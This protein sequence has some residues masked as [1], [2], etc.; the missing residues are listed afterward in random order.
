MPALELTQL[1]FESSA[2]KRLL[3]FMMEENVYLKN[4]ISEVVQ[5]S[6]GKKKLNEVEIFQNKFIMQ[7]E[8]IGLLRNDVAEFDRLLR[9][10]VIED[11]KIIADIGRK[12]RQLDEHI[13]D[14]EK[15][16]AKLKAEY[17]RFLHDNN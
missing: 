11:E 10:E 15:Q 1:Q 12:L 3:G 8:F 2:L 7:D 17:S 5:K 16:F 6:F 4:M 13:K 14:A 9:V